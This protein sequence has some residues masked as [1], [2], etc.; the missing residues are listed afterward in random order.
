MKRLWSIFVLGLVLAL[1]VLAEEGY[2]L[3]KIRWGMSMAEVQAAEGREPVFRNDEAMAY[4][5]I[6]MAAHS[7]DLAY[8]FNDDRLYQAI[9]IWS[10]K[11]FGAK[12][13]FTVF[14][15]LKEL[16][17]AKYGPSL[18]DDRIWR[19]NL[20]RDDPDSWELAVTTGSL[21]CY[22]FWETERT[23]ITLILT[24]KNYEVSLMVGYEAKEMQEEVEQ[25]EREKDLGNL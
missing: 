18:R 2:D 24:G 16:L 3:R 23:A 10:D 5:G 14:D 13:C 9:Y 19:N 4:A 15:N 7:F 6:S 17:N 11:S 25:E 8:Y 20:Y 21:S 1:P 12:E 22:A